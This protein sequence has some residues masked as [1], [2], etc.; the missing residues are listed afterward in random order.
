MV[1]FFYN[2][3]FNIMRLNFRYEGEF[4]Q[5]K[6]HGKGVFMRCD[7]MKYIGEYQNG[8]ISGLGMCLLIHT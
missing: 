4:K 8:K 7:G 6:F 2:E 3:I 5:G 1:F